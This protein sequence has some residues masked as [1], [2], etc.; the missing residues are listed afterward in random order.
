M[1]IEID[2]SGVGSVT[3][4]L[5][6]GVEEAAEGTRD[7]L[8]SVSKQEARNVITRRD[9]I[10]KGELYRNIHSFSTESNKS[11]YSGKVLADA[12]H[13]G[14]IERGA[15]YGAEGP[16]VVALI[17]WVKSQMGAGFSKGG[18]T[19][20]YNVDFEDET[21]VSGS[22]T[23]G[24]VINESDLT[25][26]RGRFYDGDY[27]LDD[28][29]ESFIGQ[30]VVYWDAEIEEYVK[31]EVTGYG[32]PKGD[33]PEITYYDD[34][35]GVE[36][37]FRVDD[38]SPHSEVAWVEDYLDL[39][40]TE[41]RSVIESIYDQT[42][43]R[44][45]TD[46]VA[47]NVN[48]KEGLTETERSLKSEQR[49]RSLVEG[50]SRTDKFTGRDDKPAGL[51]NSLKGFVDEGAVGAED[52]YINDKTYGAAEI[53][54]TTIHES[55]HLIDIM[56]D[57]YVRTPAQLDSK[58][59]KT[60]EMDDKS[61]D[62]AINFDYTTDFSGE[63]TGQY[64]YTDAVDYLLSEGE[65]RRQ[66]FIDYAGK[67]LR[68]EA[69]DGILDVESETK[70]FTSLSEQEAADRISSGDG[71]SAGDY[72]KATVS[73]SD[74][75]E[76]ET[77]RVVSVNDDGL[78]VMARFGRYNLKSEDGIKVYQNGDA[79][80][81]G[82]ANDI[83]YSSGS[84]DRDYLDFESDKIEDQLYEGINRAWLRQALVSS[85]YDEK[86][87]DFIREGYYLGRRYSIKA[88]NET[89]AVAIQMWVSKTFMRSRTT[90]GKIAANLYQ[91]HPELFYALSQTYEPSNEFVG[92][93]E[94]SLGV[95]YEELVERV[96]P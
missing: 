4:L 15:D 21:A 37:T 2:V 86:N 38:L 66:A 81:F 45:L 77:M 95:K 5:K 60:Q 69:S 42:D 9:A 47:Y 33:I 80:P 34:F 17:P 93:I 52:F 63:T 82:D 76:R 29:D 55:Q 94:T 24:D 43:K 57:K 36:K 73:H 53:K 25:P 14:A 51:S 54:D 50:V 3:R 96:S 16:P 65:D 30:T 49:L 90:P 44:G 41:R 23:K 79:S 85:I 75:S 59:G 89:S 19:R 27:S 88:A 10:W 84:K 74:G 1:K 78:T 32:G 92:A 31:A 39:S 13:A 70:S 12:E 11:S 18:Y 20:E 28:Q 67:R 7:N 6:N 72:L 83:K 58:G 40:E 26:S 71:I 56:E 64:G 62:K 91:N 35:E 68:S 61:P 22:G 8:L 48:V 87:D 46:V